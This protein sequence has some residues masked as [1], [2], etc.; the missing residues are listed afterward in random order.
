M[1]RLQH[2]DELEMNSLLDYAHTDLEVT[3]YGQ[4]NAG[5]D[6]RTKES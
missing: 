5:T 6:S 3:N 4:K 1:Q 2:Q